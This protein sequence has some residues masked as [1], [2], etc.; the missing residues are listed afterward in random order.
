MNHRLPSLPQIQH[1]LLYRPPDR[2]GGTL[3]VVDE[4]GKDQELIFFSVE[5]SA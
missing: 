4:D 1:K 3:V 5:K 2:G